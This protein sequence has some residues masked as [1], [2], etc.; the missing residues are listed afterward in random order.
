MF[1]I[2]LAIKEEKIN[3]HPSGFCGSAALPALQNDHTFI[4]DLLVRESI[5]NSSDAARKDASVYHVFYNTGTYNN[6]SLTRYFDK[7]TERKLNDRY[8]STCSFLEIRDKNTVGL[9]GETILS[10]RNNSTKSNFMRLI[11]D[12]GKGQDEINAGGKWGY[13]KTVYYRLGNGI[14]IYYSR[15]KTG[16]ENYES[17]LMFTLIENETKEDAILKKPEDT[18]AG[19]A[20]W[21]KKIGEDI[22]P[23]TDDSTIAKFLKLFGLEPFE[24]DETGT[25]IIIPYIN[26]TALI[27]EAKSGFKADASLLERCTFLN[28]VPSYLKYAIQKWYAPI[29]NNFELRKYGRKFLNAYVNGDDEMIRKDDMYPIFKLVQELYT[30]AYAKLVKQQYNS[31][32]PIVC[33][34][35]EGSFR[36]HLYKLGYV[37]F[38]KIQLKDLQGEELLLPP[39]VYMN[40]SDTDYNGSITLYTRDLGMVL[41]YDETWVNSKEFSVSPEE[42]LVAFFVPN[43]STEIDF[44]GEDVNLGAYLRVRE[45]ADHMKWDDDPAIMKVKCVKQ[46]KNSVDTAVR[47][48]F[49]PESFEVYEESDLSEFA[50]ILGEKLFPREK[51]MPKGGSGGG[52]SGGGTGRSEKGFTF[53]A[54]NSQITPEGRIKVSYELELKENTTVAVKTKVSSAVAIDAEKWKEKIGTAYPIKVMNLVIDTK[55]AEAEINVC[56]ENSEVI[57]SGEKNK[58]S[59]TFEIEASDRELVFVIDCEEKRKGDNK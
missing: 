6:Q 51:K 32:Y 5:Q 45:E 2:R 40:V 1:N 8:P 25:S 58:I 53:F 47:K 33:K 13:G 4:L 3:E 56:E 10:K 19:R 41:N 24:E 28:S 59:G 16:G 36:Q 30:T 15:V 14:V 29:I 49:N 50:G 38:S 39:N 34:E 22:C 20:W 55:A 43:T 27:E 35:S 46:I 23:I 37:A 42:L 52:G 21:G 54:S 57:V 26:E 48:H 31:M 17:R 18:S 7:D 12:M 44:G 9:T 11:F